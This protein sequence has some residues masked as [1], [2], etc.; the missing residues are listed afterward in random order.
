MM[1]HEEILM[2]M[3]LGGHIPQD[4]CIGINVMPSSLVGKGV[5]CCRRWEPNVFRIGL[6]EFPITS[7]KGEFVLLHELGHVVTTNWDDRNGNGGRINYHYLE[8]YRAD[9][10]AFDRRPEFLKIFGDESRD[11]IYGL[12]DDRQ[13]ALGPNLHWDQ[14]AIDF[15]RFTP[16]TT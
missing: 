11:M 9:K 6:Q 12:C 1:K 8:E 2:E 7:E 16:R 14:E 13:A 4:F 10:W 5:G 3:V 15:A